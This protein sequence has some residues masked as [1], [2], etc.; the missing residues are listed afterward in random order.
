MGQWIVDR[1]VERLARENIPAQN[2]YP[3]GRKPALS[4]GCAA[5]SLEKLEYDTR[6]AVVQAHVLMP[7]EQGGYACQELALQVGRVLEAMGATVWQEGCK[8]DGYVDAFSVL[9]RG[10]FSGADVMEQWASDTNFT[11]KL[12]QMTMTHAVR[13]QAE[14]AVDDV[15]GEPLS[16]A[17]WNLW[18]E[19]RFGQ[20]EGPMPNPAEPFEVTVLRSGSTEIYRQCQWI[21]VELTNTATGLKQVRKGVARS[22]SFASLG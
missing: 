4:A 12:G 13:F 17:V 9:V 3:G 14:Q 20:G 19:E 1:V 6:T 10:S 7:V 11:V 21:S 8:F 15:T 22:R 16:S 2:A 5:V 18:L